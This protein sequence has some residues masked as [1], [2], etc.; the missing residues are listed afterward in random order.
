MTALRVLH[1]DDE[2]DIR[3]MVRI[4]LGQDSAFT[5]RTC[6]SSR[7]ALA[8]VSEWSPHL[9]LS[10]VAM[11]GMDGP[12][13]LAR[14][15]DNEDTSRIPVVFM[16]ARSQT[17]DLEHLQKLGAAGVIAKPFD[18]VRLSEAVRR[19]LLAAGTNAL[20]HG[21]MR[22]LQSDAQAF[23]QCRSML[24]RDEETTSVLANIK[25]YAH[26]LAGA[27]GMFGLHEVGRRARELEEAVIGNIDGAD[28]S[29][30]Q[31]ALDR[32]LAGMQLR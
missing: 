15:R 27:A 5:V 7:D 31:V 30:V 1:I 10:D 22:R 28:V 12:A 16:T 14:L 29:G 20:F 26:A 9:I 32:L 18:P 24:E 8:V 11:P 17:K 6:A 25:A 21:F 3:A 2:P 23:V 19:H 4:S 13:M